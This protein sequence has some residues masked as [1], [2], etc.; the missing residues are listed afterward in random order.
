MADLISAEV[1]DRICNHMNKDHADAV[2]LYAKV[3]GQANMAT[4]AQLLAVD[5]TGMSLN[6]EVDGAP[7]LVRIQFEQPLQEAKDAHHVLVGMMKQAQ[8]KQLA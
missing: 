2:L 5:Q 1:S 8:A 6:A 7:T 3:F 4:A